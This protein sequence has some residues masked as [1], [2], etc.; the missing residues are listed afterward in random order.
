MKGDARGGAGD[1]RAG[2]KA[3]WIARGRALLEEMREALRPF[4]CAPDEDV[5][6]VADLHPCPGYTHHDRRIRFCPPVVERPADRIRWLVFRRMMGCADLPEARSFYD[7]ALPLVIFHEATHHLRMRDGLADESHF[8][9]EQVCDRVAVALMREF[10]YPTEPLRLAC[11]EMRD[12]LRAR[13]TDAGW[14]FVPETAA[15]LEASRESLPPPVMAE[16]REVGERV[17]LVELMTLAGVADEEV[18]AARAAR[19]QARTLVDVDY[20]RDPAAYWHLSLTWVA[21]YLRAP[22]TTMP[23]TRAVPTF[24]QR[25]DDE[26]RQMVLLQDLLA[27]GDEQETHV[28]ARA[29]LRRFGED[30]AH[31]LVDAFDRPG[32]GRA[33]REAWRPEWDPAPVERALRSGGVEAWRLAAKARLRGPAQAHDAEDAWHGAA[34]RS[35]TNEAA[36]KRGEAGRSHTNDAEAKRREDGSP[37]NDAEVELHRAVAR[38]D[39][40]PVLEGLEAEDPVALEVAL[41]WGL[42]LPILPAEDRRRILVATATRAEWAAV[43]RRVLQAHASTEEYRRA[44]E[45]VLAHDG[46]DALA[47]LA[48]RRGT[49]AYEAIAARAPVVAPTSWGAALLAGERL[50]VLAERR[51]EEAAAVI[52]DPVLAPLGESRLVDVACAYSPRPELLHLAAERLRRVPRVAREAIPEELRR[53]WDAAVRGEAS[54]AD[55]WLPKWARTLK[56]GEGEGAMVELV[57]RLV[58]LRSVPLFAAVGPEPLAELA[59]RTAAVRFEAGEAIFAEGDEGDALWVILEGSV[60][61]VAKGRVVATLRAPEHVGEMAILDGRP[62]SATARACTSLRLLRL[63]G[64]ALREVGRAF[65]AVYEGLLRTLSA[66]LRDAV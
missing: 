65:P 46:A 37:A 34:G 59:E 55:H 60:E 36:V 17:S 33:L 57:E 52:G 18:E 3:A 61:I 16:L 38:G 12:R 41:A 42:R 2:T 35:P 15:V 48:T 22:E 27:H 58:A 49:P 4:G 30:V 23:L 26:V 47:A 66:R 45:I 9:E 54:G 31:D 20:A 63:D 5:E 64:A 62:R 24:L 8:V 14:A 25:S 19:E 29:L 43:A 56:T 28:A 40:R 21:E 51:L 10:G 32:V 7:A 6:V 13:V 50:T 1:P 53:A 44:A 39:E 11:E